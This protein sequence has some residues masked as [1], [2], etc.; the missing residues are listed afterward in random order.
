M[1]RQQ[2]M[3]DMKIAMKAHDSLRLGVIR[4]IYSEIKNR[5]IDAKHELTDE[6]VIELLRKEVKRRNEAV[7]QFKTANR[8]D[9]VDQETA[10]L[11]IMKQYTPQE[12]DRSAVEAVVRQVIETQPGQNFG[13]IMKAAMQELKGKA[14]GK[15]VS[16]VVKD[17]TVQA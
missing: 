7:E 16:E 6:E 5:E 14:D 11:A 8:T 15:L 3:E 1:L 10:E 12:M 13:Q 4:Y 17:L 2:I 9:L